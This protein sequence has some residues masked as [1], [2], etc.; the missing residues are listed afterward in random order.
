MIDEVLFEMGL[1]AQRR[2]D[3]WVI[4]A[5]G[6]A[7]C[8]LVLARTGEELRVEA[9]LADWDQIAGAAEQALTMFLRR[10][11]RELKYAT[12]EVRDRGAMLVA[13]MAVRDVEVQLA[14]LVGRLLAAS[15]ALLWEAAALLRPGLAK[16]CG[17]GHFDGDESL[18]APG[19]YSS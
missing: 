18:V 5:S 19:T 12:C 6:Y 4:P 2:G 3:G 11:A 9:L 15:R 16:A 10:A 1:P 7:P 8:E 13:R 14:P 17:C